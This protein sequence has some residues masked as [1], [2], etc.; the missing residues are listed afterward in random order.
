MQ[1]GN[2]KANFSFNSLNSFVPFLQC[3]HLISSNEY[4]IW[5]RNISDTSLVRFSAIIQNFIAK[6]SAILSSLEGLVTVPKLSPN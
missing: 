4:G 3:M 1:M 5:I 2:Y 6:S